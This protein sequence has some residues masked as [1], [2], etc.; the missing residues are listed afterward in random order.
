[1]KLVGNIYVDFD[2]IYQIPV[3]YSALLRYWRKVG[4][5]WDCASDIKRLKGGLPF[6][7]KGRLIQKIYCIRY[8]TESS[9]VN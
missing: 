3:R 2:I 9:Y 5:Q 1:M 8:K 4:V 6:Y 7:C